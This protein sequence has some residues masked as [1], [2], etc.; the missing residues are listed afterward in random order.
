MGIFVEGK[1]LIFKIIASRAL[2]KDVAVHIAGRRNAA[3]FLKVMTESADNR[4]P[5]GII[6][7]NALLASLVTFAFAGRINSR[8]ILEIVTKSGNVFL[9]LVGTAGVA[10][11]GRLAPV[12]A[13]GLKGHD[14]VIPVMLNHIGHGAVSEMRVAGLAIGAAGETGLG[15]SRGNILIGNRI[16]VVGINGGNFFFGFVASRADEGLYSR[17]GAGG[18]GGDFAF[19]PL[20]IESGNYLLLDSNL[21]ANRAVLALGQ[22]GLG[23]GGGNGL[24]DDLGMTSGGDGLNICPAT[25]GAHLAFFVASSV[26]VGSLASTS[27]RSCVT[28]I[29]NVTLWRHQRP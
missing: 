17:V 22:T 6:A 28:V 20:V 29:S 10:G 16:V 3:G 9:D 25:R 2:F 12:V 14:T 18:G 27:T 4:E 5:L 19:V 1:F 24:I 15:A 13:R 23:A 8:N 11:I 21:A 26:Q 7:A